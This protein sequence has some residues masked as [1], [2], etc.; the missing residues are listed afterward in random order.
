[1]R[2]LLALVGA[3]VILVAVVGW[4][5]NWY[6][7]ETGPASGGHQSVN[8][9]IDRSRIS[10]DIQRGEERL[11]DALER[12]RKDSATPVEA[13]RKEPTKPDSKFW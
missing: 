8:I 11:H 10:N 9:E 2:N 12:S 5:R 3:A 6:S 1:M 13:P 4:Y 7:I